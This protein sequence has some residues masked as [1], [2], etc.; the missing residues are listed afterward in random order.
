[1]STG[2]RDLAV[3]D[4]V[5]I[6][7]GRTPWEVTDPGNYYPAGPEGEPFRLVALRSQRSGLSRWADSEALRWADTGEPVGGHAEPASSPPKGVAH[8]SVS[9]VVIGWDAPVIRGRQVDPS[10]VAL[11]LNLDSEG[12]PFVLVQAD[13]PSSSGGAFLDRAS[14]LSLAADLRRLAGGM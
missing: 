8:D 10:S 13:G 9:A 4:V 1:M 2:A 3:G 6:G 7:G 11:C 5:H 14:V 12:R